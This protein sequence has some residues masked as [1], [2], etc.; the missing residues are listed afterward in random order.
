MAI[1]RLNKYQFERFPAQRTPHVS[2]GL[3]AK[4]VAWFVD[5]ASTVLGVILLDNAD[6]DW[7]YVVL[8][9]DE[10]GDFRWIDGNSSFDSLEKPEAELK[11]KMQ[12]FVDSGEKVFPQGD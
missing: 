1:N 10:H 11:T 2:M 12:P 4:E 3:I 5:S 9:R 6:K 8:G 7:N